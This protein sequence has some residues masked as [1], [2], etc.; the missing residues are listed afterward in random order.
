MESVS[1]ICRRVGM[2]RQNYYAQR[3]KRGEKELAEERV[4]E[5]VQEERWA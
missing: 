2:S 1:G 3:R 4:V 5:L